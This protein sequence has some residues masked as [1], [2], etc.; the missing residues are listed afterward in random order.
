MI[1]ID[2]N[3]IITIR[4]LRKKLEEFTNFGEPVILD[5]TIKELKSM[6]NKNSKLALSL[7]KHYNF[8][9]IKTR[10]QCPADEAILNI[11]TPSDAVVTNDKKLIKRLKAKGVNIIRLRQKKYLVLER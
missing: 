8:K 5:N 2:T 4:N 10:L 3:A 1:I 6:K 7:L 9:I 11:A